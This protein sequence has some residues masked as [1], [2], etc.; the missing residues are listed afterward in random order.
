VERTSDKLFARSGLSGDD[1]APGVRRKP[2]D[3]VEEVLHRRAAADDPVK[4]ELPGG[5]RVLLQ[6][7]LA[8]SDPLDD[9][10]QRVAQPIKLGWSAQAV[11]HAELHRLDRRIDARLPGHEDDGARGI[12]VAHRTE[13][14]DSIRAR[15]LQ[16]DDDRVWPQLTNVLECVGDTAAADDVQPM[17]ARGVLDEREGLGGID[18]SEQVD[19]FL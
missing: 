6:P 5:L 13:H 4:L 15:R 2:P 8:P 12:D 11:E 14:F 3:G 18:D 16:V 1:Q 19:A 10:G 9:R 7:R 17:I